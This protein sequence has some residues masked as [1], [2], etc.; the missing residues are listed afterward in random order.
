MFMHTDG[1][2]QAAQQRTHF[3]SDSNPDGV[4]H[5]FRATKSA[6]R[7][8]LCCSDRL[9]HGFCGFQVVKC[10][11]RMCRVMNLQ[12]ETLILI[13]KKL[14]RPVFP[15]ELRN[16]SVDD[17]RLVLPVTNG[18]SFTAFITLCDL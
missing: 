7:R 14:P 9:Y 6:D 3:H 4:F 1:L 8:I 5:N 12:G 17:C 11:V 13:E 15:P 18:S 16:Q 10:L 2:A